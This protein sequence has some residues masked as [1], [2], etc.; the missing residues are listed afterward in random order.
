MALLAAAPSALAPMVPAALIDIRASVCGKGLGGFATRDLHMGERIIA[1]RPLVKCRRMTGEG[2]ALV[3]EALSESE[4]E[5]FFA[6]SQS[7]KHGTAKSPLGI[8]SSNAFPTGD[9]S[10]TAAVYA[11]ICRLNHD[12]RPNAHVCWNENIGMQTVHALRPIRVGEEICVAYIGGDADG[13]RATRQSVLHEKFSFTCACPQCQLTG[14]ALAQSEAR[15]RRLNEIVVHLK[16]KPANTVAIV[17]E[18]L[19]L[20]EVESMP[21][22]WCKA[23][24]LRALEHVL[25]SRPRPGGNARQVAWTLAR[26]AQQSCQIAMGDDAQETVA[27][28]SFI[29]HPTFAKLQRKAGKE[30]GKRGA[31]VSTAGGT[32]PKQAEVRGFGTVEQD[33]HQLSVQMQAA[34]KALA[35]TTAK[36]EAAAEREAAARTQAS[37][38]VVELA[39]Q[40]KQLLV[41]MHDGASS[42]SWAF[43]KGTFDNLKISWTDFEFAAARLSDGVRRVL[44][45]DTVGDELLPYLRAAPYAAHWTATTRAGARSEILSQKAT[46]DASGCV[47]LRDAIDTERDHTMDTV[48]HFAQHTLSLTLE[49]LGALV[50]QEAVERLLHFPMALLRQRKDE[51]AAKLREAWAQASEDMAPAAWA[52]DG[53]EGAGTACVQASMDVARAAATLS[54]KAAM[55]GFSVDAYVRR[56][57]RHTRP[58]LGFHTDR[59]VVTINVALAPDAAHEGGRLHAVL[60][61]GHRIVEREEGEA[62]VHGDDVMH[63]VSAM[64]SGVRYSLVMLFFLQQ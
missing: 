10:D 8:W 64:R 13:T 43:A 39:S 29:A 61:G 23:S 15:Q 21:V 57:S 60:G 25:P 45:H 2:L 1:E 16:T 56:Y 26:D 11:V 36:A 62:T 37:D 28:A 46:L 59:S 52:G 22:V 24:V 51:A 19:S 42:S 58:W 14:A 55:C 20:M 53:Q 33:L 18:R 7:E 30:S 32:A 44:V 17:Q 40:H 4:R 41:L 50:G 5:D 63:G 35:E 31:L 27:L 3:V 47:A 12:C 38:A 54:G 49:R 34:T 48:D 9:N 6:L